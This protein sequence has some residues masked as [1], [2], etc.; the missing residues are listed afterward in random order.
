MVNYP[1][2]LFEIV[3][4]EGWWETV[5]KAF[6]RNMARQESPSSRLLVIL[7]VKSKISDSVFILVSSVSFLFIQDL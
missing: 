5:L 1:E 2:F 6:F 3:V 7:S 4:L